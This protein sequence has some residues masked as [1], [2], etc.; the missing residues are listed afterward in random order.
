MG[1][2]LGRVFQYGPRAV[3]TKPAAWKIADSVPADY[4]DTVKTIGI[5]WPMLTKRVGVVAFA[6]NVLLEVIIRLRP[7]LYH[8][9]DERLALYASQIMGAD[10]DVSVPI[11][12]I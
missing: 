6:A 8:M 5:G 9:D 7:D 4:V 3:T 1:Y 11:K 12:P 2:L 10:C